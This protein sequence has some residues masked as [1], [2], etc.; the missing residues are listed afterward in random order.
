MSNPAPHILIA[1]DH[2][3][4][5]DGLALLIRGF[6]PDCRIVHAQDKA[7]V[8]QTLG[9]EGTLDL[10]LV[11]WHM[12]PASAGLSW[13]RIL[14]GRPDIPVVVVSA[15]TSPPVMRQAMDIA[16]VY[17]F[18]PKSAD[19]LILHSAMEAAMQR[20]KFLGQSA[21]PSCTENAPMPPRLAEVLPLLRRGMS[22]KM[23]ARELNISV[24]TVRNYLS[25]IYQ[26]LG[27]GNRTQAALLDQNS[28]PP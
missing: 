28:S 16:S 17:A 12:P 9:E 4:V 26:R 24:G 25:E 19:A 21:V 10:A 8:L 20:I 1:D 5:R 15:D 23:I 3:L 7:A 2:R 14:A 6:W 11:D 27:V 18:V 22:N 13:Q